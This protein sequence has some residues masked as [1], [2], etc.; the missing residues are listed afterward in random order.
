MPAEHTFDWA[1]E[2]NEGREE[3]RREEKQKILQACYPVVLAH[4]EERFGPLSEETKRC[5]ETIDSGEEMASL[6][7]RILFAHSLSELGLPS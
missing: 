5:V 1:R 4:L 7:K 2:W 3:G 6:L